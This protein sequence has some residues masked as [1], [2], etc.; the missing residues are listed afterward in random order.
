MNHRASP[1][2][3]SL[4]HQLPEPIQQLADS[5]FALLRADPRH[6]SLHFRRVGRFWSARVGLHYRALAV[7]RD[8]EFVWFWIGSHAEYDQLVGR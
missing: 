5:S 8:Q 3:W 6:P 4:Y 1:R 2:F 7:Q